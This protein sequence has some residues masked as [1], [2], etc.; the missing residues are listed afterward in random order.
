MP[1]P[2]PPAHVENNEDNDPKKIT[3]A[4]VIQMNQE[5]D[6]AWVYGPGT[7]TQLAAR[8]FL[9][10]KAPGPDQE[11]DDNAPDGGANHRSASPD[12]KVKIR[13]TSMAKNDVPDESS[14]SKDDAADA[15]PKTRAGVVMSEK[16]PMT[17]GFSENMEFTGRSI[18]PE[19]NPAA[20]AVFHGIVT[21][22]MEDALLHCTEKMIAYTDREVPLT[23]LGKMS[24]AQSQP[25]PGNK[26]ANEEGAAEPQA[27]LTLINCYRKALAI[28]RKVDPDAP[29]L[30]QQQRIDAV[31]FLAYDRRTG[32]FFVPGKGK[33]FLYDRNADSSQTSG[34]N[35]DSDGNDDGVGNGNSRLTATQRTVTQDIGPGAET[36]KRE[37]WRKA[38]R[39][40]R[41]KPAQSATCN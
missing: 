37:C 9:T 15:K 4:G 22:Q 8:G 7:L 13:T 32:D 23:Q 41:S 19:G 6:R 14:T 1:G 26:A 24:Q 5:T 31:D 18:D 27:E 30:I 25:K 3:A 33:V 35:P 11:A 17:I 2:W 34:S 39:C 10:D 20:Q 38:D 36:R 12:S 29:I 40:S 28:S 16:A 21:A